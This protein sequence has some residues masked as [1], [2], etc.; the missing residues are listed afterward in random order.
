MRIVGR[1]SFDE[2][3]EVSNKVFGLAELG[4]K[5]F[6]T[7]SFL[8]S[9]LKGKG[10]STTFPY[11]DMKTSFRAEYGT[12]KPTV[13]FLCE[14]DALPNGHSCG[15]NLIA[16]WAVG[17]AIK[18]KESG[19]NGKIVVIGTPSEEGIGEYSGSKERMVRRGAFKD[20]DFVLGFHP[21]SEWNVGCQSPNDITF[22][23][24]FKG[25]ASDMENV[26]LG[27]N[28]LDALVYVYNGIRKLESSKRYSGVMAGMF[29]KEGGEAS[30]IVPE[31][32]RMEVD[33]RSFDDSIF[34]S[35]YNK[36]KKLTKSAGRRYGVKSSLKEL[37]PVYKVYHNAREID[38]VLFKNLAKH[39][40]KPNKLHIGNQH[41]MGATD[42]ANVSVV[43]STGHL[44]M[45][46]APKTVPGHSDSFR[47]HA[48]S[49]GALR[50]LRTAIDATVESCID[51]ERD[52]ET[53]DKI[54]MLKRNLGV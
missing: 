18:L 3:V 46:I 6:R 7:S 44:D 32:A 28:A 23:L 27:R 19:Y 53:L 24:V 45:K 51:I 52:T 54:Y 50:A 39:G 25:K 31:A 4:S 41:Q 1:T 30:N 43:V 9:F 2:I 15:H 20:I 35:A 10:F 22:D 14:E 36:I 5:E 21:D 17:S 37:T 49:K 38:E 8:N 29:I 16:A 33:L 48:G 13:C 47:S 12:G 34:K 42:E 40:I 26:Q 11:C